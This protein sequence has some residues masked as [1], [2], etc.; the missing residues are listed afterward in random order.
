MFETVAEARRRAKKW[1]PKAVYGA[2]I[3]GSEREVTLEDN[4]AAFGE[5]GF[6]PARDQAAGRA[7]SDDDGA[8][9]AGITACH[10]LAHRRS[11]RASGWG[12]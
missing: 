2:L 8:R 11:G 6:R 5:L 10:P 9:P 7:R 4:M 1:L 3:A 12:A